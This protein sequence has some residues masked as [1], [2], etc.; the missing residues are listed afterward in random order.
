MFNIIKF[1]WC[2]QRKTTQF[3][4]KLFALIEYLYFVWLRFH[5]DNLNSQKRIFHIDNF[6]EQVKRFRSTVA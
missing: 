2:I 6:R 4:R 3:V 5:S 1:S